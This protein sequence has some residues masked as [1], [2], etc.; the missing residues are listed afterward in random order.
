MDIHNQKIKRI[1]LTLPI[2]FFVVLIGILA[3]LTLETR[4]G[5]DPSIVPSALI[6][7]KAP[8]INLPAISDDIPGGF[9][10][11]DLLGR[12]TILNVF[13]SWCAPCLIEHKQI[14]KLSEIGIPVFAI[15]HHDKVTDVTLWL[16]KHGNPYEA[17]GFDP[18]G[19][20]SIEWGVS[21]LPE[22]YI[23]NANGII[24]YKHSGPITKSVLKKKILPEL[25]KAK[26]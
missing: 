24:T 4:E 10:R 6:G 13:A 2:L 26:K 25:E 15:N 22:T 21:G 12:V 19:R 1:L 5:R 18:D 17:I 23:I 16:K 3:L 20:A 11:D 7:K 8:T 14:E 9:T